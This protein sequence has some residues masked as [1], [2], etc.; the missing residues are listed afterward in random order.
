MRCI[1]LI[2]WPPICLLLLAIACTDDG[3]GAALP[4]GGPDAG[5]GSEWPYPI[6]SV[7]P[8]WE[9][10]SLFEGEADGRAECATVMAPL[11][12][13]DPDDGRKVPI[14][15]KRLLAAGEA[16]AQLWL[17]AGGPGQ[18]GLYSYP[19]YMEYLQELYPGVDVYT[20]DHRGTG[21]SARL[22]C[23]IAEDPDSSS[24]EQ[25]TY[26]ESF[27]CA[28]YLQEIWGDG[29]D[30]IIA[31]ASAID[32]A[33][34][35]EGSRE[36]DKRVIVHGGSYG[37]YFVLRYLQ[38]FPDQVDGAIIEA[39]FPPDGTFIDSDY[40]TNEV[41][42]E[43]F[44][45]CGADE[46]CA[47]KLGDDPWARLGEVLEAMRGGHCTASGLSAD[48]VRV[49]FAYALYSNLL[50]T[51][52]PA[53]VYRLER[54]EP[55]DADAVYSLYEFLFGDGGAWDIESY[56]VLLQHHVM[57]SEMWDHPDFEGVDLAEYFDTLYET[58]YVAKLSSEAKL[59]LLNVWPVYADELYDD[60]FPATDIPLLM[61]QGEIDPA[62][63]LAK[64]APLAERYTAA[65]QHFV[66]FP[67][68]A[69][70]VCGASPTGTESG[71]FDCGNRLM[72][73]FLADP[74][75][76][77]DTSCAQQTLPLDFS[78]SPGLAGLVFGTPD[79]YEN[80]GVMPYGDEVDAAALEQRIRRQL[81]AAP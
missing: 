40:Y 64:A 5:P 1:P 10:C 32:L 58:T 56:S 77:L 65:H 43:V 37:S 13:D 31:S 51:L 72:L 62:C 57:F 49:V 44:A 11:F 25:I 34:F 15:A 66:T 4:D 3:G 16:D 9:Q 12:W 29:L 22:E 17:L 73:D 48:A 74:T 79:P 52:L 39:I 30:G 69:H 76:P 67:N 78:G 59:N 70:G 20:I 46:T 26:G 63:P 6:D 35:I 55:E 75:A 7:A 47:A 53:T 33:A 81:A 68:A 42:R 14:T 24:A 80:D 23:P 50:A 28:E 60:G 21:K 54:C 27:A 2:P 45:R 61:L 41:A 38:I 71:D 19:P 36:P 8:V 18:S